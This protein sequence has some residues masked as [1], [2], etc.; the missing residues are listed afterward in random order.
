MWVLMLRFSEV[1]GVKGGAC[2]WLNRGEQEWLFLAGH[3]T[4]KGPALDHQWWLSLAH[5]IP[6]LSGG[7]SVGL[8]NYLWL[9]ISEDSF[10]SSSRFLSRALSLSKLPILRLIM[11]LPSPE[12]DYLHVFLWVLL[13]SF[14]TCT[15]NNREQDVHGMCLRRSHQPN[16]KM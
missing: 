3:Q 6:E 15:C 7:M 11:F 16:I 14:M 12:K 8:F 4:L 13:H 2:R 1:G 9:V 5:R 10:C